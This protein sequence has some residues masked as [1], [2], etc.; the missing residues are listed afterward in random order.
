MPN[1]ATTSNPYLAK[2]YNKPHIDDA[3][4]LALAEAG[5]PSRAIQEI[6]GIGYRTVCRRLKHLTPRKTTDIYK[7]FRADI[8]AEKQRKLLMLSHN[9]P[10]NE[11]SKAAIAFGVYYDKERLER[12]LSTANA[13]VQV[14][15]TDATSTLIDRVVSRSIPMPSTTLDT[16]VHDSTIHS[17]NSI[18]DVPPSIPPTV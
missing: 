4:I 11:Q 15:L 2:Q 3:V 7:T 9:A 16:Q 5:K 14:G 13:S 1:P 10:L 18:V 17:N 6:T 8:L 12:G